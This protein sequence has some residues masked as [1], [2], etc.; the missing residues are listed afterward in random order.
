MCG[1]NATVV[2]GG[3]MFVFGGK[4]MFGGLAMIMVEQN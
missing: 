4:E 2:G 1:G 3:G